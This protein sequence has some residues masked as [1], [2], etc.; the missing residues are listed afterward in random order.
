MNLD[1]CQGKQMDKPQEDAVNTE[2]QQ[3]DKYL[4]AKASY[5][6][7]N[8]VGMLMD[9]DDILSLWLI[10]CKVQLCV[11]FHLKYF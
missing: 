9:L 4:W 11:H 2:S 3:R 6:T 5:T 8:T 7:M 10:C 1:T